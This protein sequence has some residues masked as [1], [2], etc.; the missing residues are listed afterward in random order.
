MADN[1]MVELKARVARCRIQ[2]PQQISDLFF[3]CKGEDHSITLCRQCELM[4]VFAL[5]QVSMKTLRQIFKKMII[6][7]IL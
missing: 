6:S 1:W 3:P 4:R 7:W 5:R 2:K